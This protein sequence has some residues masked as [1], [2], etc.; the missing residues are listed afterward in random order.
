M[1]KKLY[2]QDSYLEDFKAK[3]L[4]CSSCKEGYA[5]EL[6]QTAFYPE[7]GGQPADTG[8]LNDVPVQHVFIKEGTIYHVI[9]KPIA[10]G[11]EV[12]G[13]VHFKKRWDYMQQHSG[14]HIIS[15]I[16]NKVYGYNNVGF[17]LSEE[18]MTADF[19]GELTKEQILEIEQR[20][21]EAVFNNVA[22]KDVIYDEETIK[23]K[24]YRSKI[25]LLGEVRLVTVEGYDVCACCGT[26]LRRAGEIGLIKILSAE[27]HRGGMRLTIVC[28]LRAL[29]DYQMK[30]N[31]VSELSAI[32]S[33]KQE[34]IVESVKKL[35]GESAECKQKL[36]ERTREILEYK[37]TAYSQLQE[38]IICIVEEQ[39]RPDDMRRLCMMVMEQTDA[40]CLVVVPDQEQCKYAIGAKNQDVKPL[41][42]K[43][44]EKFQ[45]KGGGN[46]QICQ[47]S[48]KCTAKEVKAYF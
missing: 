2:Y 46:S 27:R 42:K 3:V 7:G 8:L 33:A 43:L 20:A 45:G 11:D 37:A 25:Q 15:G 13:K 9:S 17:Y 10:V 12:Q 1:T 32:L 4:S 35:Q 44:N 29:R 38:D 26:H 30:T 40:V 5:L 24:S 28:G 48:L 16:V 41:S 6:D 21:N 22:I 34:V 19:D 47:G 36:A 31:I 14:E 18:Y 39:L 23:D